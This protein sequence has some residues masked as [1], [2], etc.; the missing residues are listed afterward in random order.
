MADHSIRTISTQAPPGRMAEINVE[1]TKHREKEEDTK[2][3][4]YILT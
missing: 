4:T 3:K 1:R 2:L